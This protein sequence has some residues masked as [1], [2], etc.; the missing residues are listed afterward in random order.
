MNV[1][2]VVQTRTHYDKLA[3]A[4]EHQRAGQLAEAKG[5][6]LGLLEA[7]PDDA[8]ASHLLG[9]LMHQTGNGS[10]AIGLIKK[11]L[12]LMPDTPLF[13]NNLGQVYLQC[14]QIKLAE[15]TLLKATQ[16]DPD[17]AAPLYGLAECSRRRGQFQ[18][19]A[20]FTRLVLERDPGH[21]DAIVCLGRIHLDTQSLEK[22]IELFDV[23]L[24]AKPDP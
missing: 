2:S 15:S 22:A 23:A 12:L 16:T 11:A 10:Q 9:M 17:A 1:K 7:N 20:D 3:Q 14:N 19:A 21:I 5:I 6:Y 4:L 24:S 8:N 18:Q 13:L